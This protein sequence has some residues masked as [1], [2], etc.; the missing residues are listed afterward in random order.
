MRTTLSILLI[1][2][3][4]I[5]TLITKANKQKSI[6]SLHVLLNGSKDEQRVDLLIKLAEL[7]KGVD[8]QKSKHMAKVAADLSNYM[9][10]I[11]GAAVAYLYLGEQ[12]MKSERND[13][14]Q[15]AFDKSLAFYKKLELE[16]FQSKLLNYKC[17]IYSSEG[18]Y[19]DALD[20][21]VKIL[22]IEEK[23][24]NDLGLGN[25]YFRMAKVMNELNELDQALEYFEKAKLHFNSG[26]YQLQKGNV[27]THIGMLM[28][29]MGNNVDAEDYYQQ[30]L[31]LLLPLKDKESLVRLYINMAEFYYDQNDVKNAVSFYTSALGVNKNSEHEDLKLS[32]IINSKIGECYASDLRQFEKGIKHLEE[33]LKIAKSI[34]FT[35]GEK[36]AYRSM[37]VAYAS[38]KKFKDA[39]IAQNNYSL[40]LDSLMSKT[41]NQRLEKVKALLYLEEKKV[42]EKEDEIINLERLIE[43]KRQNNYIVYFGALAIILTML[44]LLI[45]KHKKEK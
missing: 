15:I 27:Y 41:A 6:D 5:N 14:A 38:N 11:P 25:T 28:N 13:S 36:E 34:K 16:N 43:D 22:L 19:T 44:V 9:G 29:K 17:D 42:K 39:Y 3:L 33:G 32:S 18:N 26:G 21:L 31:V 30:A 1:F 45:K 40:L 35:Q 2:A 20:C 37:A 10:Y 7:Y 8:D 24:K 4:G 23:Q 12:Y